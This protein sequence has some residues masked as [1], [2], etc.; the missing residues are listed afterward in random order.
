MKSRLNLLALGCSFVVLIALLSTALAQQAAEA[1]AKKPAEKPAP[2]PLPETTVQIYQLMHADGE[3]LTATL[4]PLFTAPK[5]ARTILVFDKRTNTII[6]RG[7]KSELQILEAILLRLDEKRPE[8]P[9]PAPSSR[10]D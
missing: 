3:Q 8:Q 5:E 7:T 1:P 10:N 2:A 6:A 9:P 4:Q